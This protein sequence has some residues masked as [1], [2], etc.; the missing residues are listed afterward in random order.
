MQQLL[1]ALLLCTAP[2][3]GTVPADAASWETLTRSPV[4]VECTEVQGEPWC[5]SRGIV[6]APIDQVAGSLANMADHADL[7]QSVV[8]IEVLEEN[9]L[10]VVLDYPLPFDDRDYVARYSHESRG[11]AQFFRWKPATHPGAPETDDTVR[12]AHFQGEWHLEPRGDH[13]WVQYTWHAKISGSFPSFAL[14]TAWKRAG[15][16]ALTDLAR[17]QGTELTAP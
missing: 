17:T 14:P 2:R 15:T 1:P 4:P 16:E 11:E 9:L 6:H 12:L 10:H 13:T 8:S 5:R 3:A 7:F